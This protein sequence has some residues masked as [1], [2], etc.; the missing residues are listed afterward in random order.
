MREGLSEIEHLKGKVHLLTNQLKTVQ[1]E[2]N[3]VLSEGAG[4]QSACSKG[5]E[6]GDEED[7]VNRNSHMYITLQPRFYKL[8]TTLQ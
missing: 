4:T 3:K 8:K 5:S 2:Y 6:D 1:K 7:Q